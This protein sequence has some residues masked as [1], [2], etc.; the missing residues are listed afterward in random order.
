MVLVAVCEDDQMYIFDRQ[1]F[2]GLVGNKATRPWGTSPAR[3]GLRLVKKV[4]DTGN[5]HY[6]VERSAA[7]SEAVHFVF[8]FP[9]PGT[10]APEKWKGKVACS[11]D[12]TVVTKA[13]R[14]VIETALARAR[15][16][17]TLQN[18]QKIR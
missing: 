7:L 18:W 9:K 15:K 8:W 11:T 3:R 5:Q 4:A 14:R 6:A 1:Q 17:L 16:N 13:K 10:F 2:A 12:V